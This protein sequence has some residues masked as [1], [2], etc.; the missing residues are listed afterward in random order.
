[1]KCVPDTFERFWSIP[2]SRN[3]EEHL[4]RLVSEAY[5]Y[6]DALDATICSSTFLN[7]AALFLL[8]LFCCFFYG[9]YVC[10]PLLLVTSVSFNEHM[11]TSATVLFAPILFCNAPRS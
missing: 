4:Q 2:R 5:N 8:M 10:R 3:P 6:H 7:L 11:L 9:L 1:M